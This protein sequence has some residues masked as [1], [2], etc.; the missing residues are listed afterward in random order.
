MKKIIQYILKILSKKI[1]DKY[2][3]EIIGITGS[4][5]KTSTKDAVKRILEKDY[6]VRANI[7][8]Y[9]NE[10]GVPLTIIGEKS[11]SKSIFGWLNIISK[12]IKLILTT[13]K[14]YPKILIL[15]MGADKIGDIEYLVS[16]VRCNIAIVTNISESHLEFFHTVQ[17][18]EKEKRKIVENLKH[19]NFAIL[20]MDLDL[21]RNMKNKTKAKVI[22]FGFGKGA[23]V[24][25]TDAVISYYNKK[26]NG[27][28]FKLICNGNVVPIFMPKILGFSQI[29]SALAAV[30]VGTIY[31]INLLGIAKS[32][33]KFAPP[34]GRMSLIKGVKQTSIIDDTYNSSPLAVKSALEIMQ[35][36]K[37]PDGA[38]K[39]AVLGDML[40]LGNRSQ[41]YHKK[42]GEKVVKNGIDI[43]ITKGEAARNI[44]KGAIASGMDKNRVFS[45]SRNREAGRF[46]QDKISKNDLILLKG[47][48]GMRMEKIVKEIMAY[49]LKANELLARQGKEWL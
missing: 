34:K 39:I 17:K 44:A 37:L 28:S 38:K 11:P 19:E 16:F 46:L 15:E 29:Y 5:G 49:P 48:Q 8:N 3:P 1:L 10:I 31:K 18:I 41:D 43:L 9:N 4:V 24:R 14:N 45:F 30:A 42:T 23:D 25:A 21:T 40:E 35:E 2:K 13:D 6:K 27:V 36:I 32:L 26:P 12:G 20:N 47:S 22:T 7:K 33:E